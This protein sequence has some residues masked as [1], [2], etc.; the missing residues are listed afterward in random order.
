MQEY[1]I[2][3]LIVGV[4]ETDQGILTYIKGYGKRIL[5]P[6]FVWYLEGGPQKI[7]VDTGVDQFAVPP[8]AEEKYGIKVYEFEDAL[9]TVGL[10]PDDIDIIIHTHLHN[11][12]CEN[13]YKCPNAKVYVQKKEYEFLLNPHPADYRYFPDI[14]DGVE[15][16]PVEGD[17]EIV[18][19]VRVLFTPG[20]TLG[21]Q[22]VAVNT[23]QGKAVI[24]GLCSNAWNF[25][26][27]G[28]PVPPGIHLNLM[29]AYDSMHRLVKEADILIPLHEVAIGR[30]ARIPA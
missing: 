18:E 20:H 1:V 2:R 8:G 11:D 28:P 5:L 21:G 26:S 19:G 10:K 9:A 15:V 24:A 17:Q 29:A 16:V 30:M 6:V 22:S 4:N 13:D 23:N 3:P 14:L 27:S 12:H 25:P 7:L